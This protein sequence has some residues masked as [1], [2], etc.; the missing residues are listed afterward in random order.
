MKKLAPVNTKLRYLILH[1]VLDV[2]ILIIVDFL[3]F[4]YVE[5]EIFLV[6]QLYIIPTISY[7]LVARYKNQ[8]LEIAVDETSMKIKIMINKLIFWNKTLYLDFNDIILIRSHKWLFNAY[9]D[10][11]QINSKKKTIAVI[12]YKQSIW[13]KE[14]LDS[15]VV[16]LINFIEYRDNRKSP[17]KHSTY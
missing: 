17:Y 5:R 16:S 11:I 4:H 13:K 2:V 15:L 10:V 7:L 12:P 3:I 1:E 6:S 8:V 14:E 9:L